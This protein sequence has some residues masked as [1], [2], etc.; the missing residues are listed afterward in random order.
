M[1]CN[2]ISVPARALEYRLYDKMAYIEYANITRP[3]N[4]KFRSTCC[5]LVSLK[6]ISMGPDRQNKGK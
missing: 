2:G 5:T 1:T 3:I 6:Y 4:Q